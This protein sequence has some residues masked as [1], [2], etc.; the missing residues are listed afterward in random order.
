MEEFLVY[1]VAIK[2]WLEAFYVVRVLGRM[3]TTRNKFYIKPKRFNSFQM[4]S[5]Y[6]DYVNYLH[7]LAL[8]M[9]TLVALM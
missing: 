7:F 3:I 6:G 9:T 5:F 8:E 2:Y 4:K 1:S